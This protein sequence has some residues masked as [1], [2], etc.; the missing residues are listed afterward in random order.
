MIDGHIPIFNYTEGEEGIPDDQAAA[1][2][3]GRSSFAWMRY[4]GAKER[5]S[6]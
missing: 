6:G 1:S 3:V 5:S 2:F 4:A